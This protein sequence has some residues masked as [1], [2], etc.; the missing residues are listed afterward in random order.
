MT[1]TLISHPCSPIVLPAN[2]I[3]KSRTPGK[4]PP[5]SRCTA[6]EV[7]LASTSK[8]TSNLWSSRTPASPCTNWPSSAIM[9]PW[10]WI[11]VQRRP[12]LLNV[13]V[14]VFGSDKN[15]ETPFSR[16]IRSIWTASGVKLVL[17]QNL[18]QNRW[19]WAKDNWPSCI[20]SVR[21][22]LGKCGKFR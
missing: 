9:F 22:V 15:S 2:T 10:N 16:W 12:I 11:P 7:V 6:E 20:R 13:Q 3:K 18:R 1:T 8:K 4:A 21:E 17:L 14:Q 5:A 19:K